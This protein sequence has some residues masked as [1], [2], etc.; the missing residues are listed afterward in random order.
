M[1]QIEPPLLVPAR[2]YFLGHVFLRPRRMGPR[3]TGHPGM[4]NGPRPVPSQPGSC[5]CHPEERSD[6]GSQR[7]NEIPCCGRNDNRRQST[8]R[9]LNKLINFPGSKSP[10]VPLYKGGYRGIS[11]FNQAH[12]QVWKSI[13]GSVSPTSTVLCLPANMCRGLPRW[14]AR[15][16]P[17]GG[18]GGGDGPGPC[19]PPGPGKVPQ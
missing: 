3:R 12:D 18:Y 8:Y 17:A 14:P 7:G 9:P 6:E 2:R 13:Q 5:R 1:L 10:L 11:P 19:L 16:S 4:S 15:G